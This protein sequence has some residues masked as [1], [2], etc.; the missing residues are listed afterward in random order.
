MRL[1]RSSRFR[2][3]AGWLAVCL[4]VAGGVA[5][6]GIHFSNTGHAEKDVFEPGK[7]QLVPKAPKADS[8][9][10]RRAAAGPR[11]RGPLRRERRLPQARRRFVRPHDQRA[12][13]GA[14]S[15][16][17]GRPARSRS[18]PTRANAVDERPLAPRLL[19]R[20]RG[21]SQGRLL[22]EGP[23]RASIGR[24]STSRS[25]TT[26]RPARPAGSSP[27]GLP[28]AA[29]SSRR[30]T[31]ARRRSTRIAPKPALG[32]VWLF[33]PVGLIVGG[34][35]GVIAFLAIRGR[36]RHGAQCG[37]P[38]ST[39]R[40]RARP[41]RVRARRQIELFRPVRDQQPPGARG[42]E[43]GDRLVG[44]EVTARLAV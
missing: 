35:V 3:R 2:R 19:L 25:R 9:H 27:T 10:P 17:T 29:C 7:P 11:G 28:R 41:E 32:A 14:L 6:V 20:E 24:S 22:P 43:G 8:V 15:S 13:S 39:G 21:R 44:G 40:A 23:A 42:R 26:A 5:F 38:G 30:P 36:L 34:L 4:A 12:A 31:R 16:P 37:P 18:S 1:L 33:V